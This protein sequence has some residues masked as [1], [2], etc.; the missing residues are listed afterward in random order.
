LEVEGTGD[1]RPVFP[2]SRGGLQD[3]TNTARALRGVIDACNPR[4]MEWLYAHRK[5]LRSLRSLRMYQARAR[6]WQEAQKLRN[7]EDLIDVK[8][9]SFHDFR[10]TFASAMIAAGMDAPRLSLLLG[11]ADPAFTMRT[12]AHFFEQRER[13]SMP[14]I[15]QFLEIRGKIRGT[16]AEDAEG[17]EEARPGTL[18]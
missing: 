13:P 17:Q 18:S 7:F 16:D 10:H 5:E 6:A 1:S 2:N 11:H 8:Y 12:Y 14:S 3:E 15:T 4:L 9:V